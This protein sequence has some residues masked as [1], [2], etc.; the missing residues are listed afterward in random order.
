MSDALGLSATF[1]LRCRSTSS[2]APATGD[3]RIA[4]ASSSRAAAMRRTSWRRTRPRGRRHSSAGSRFQRR[5]RWRPTSCCATA[6]SMRK[7]RRSRRS[8]PGRFASRSHA[9]LAP[10]DAVVAE[11]GGSLRLFGGLS[12]LLARLTEGAR[13][14]GYAARL[15]ARAHAHAALVARTRPDMRR[16]CRDARALAAR[17]GAGLPLALLDVDADTRAT[18]ASAGITTFGEADALPRDG[19]ARRFG[20][21]LL[22]S[23]SIA[24]SARRARSARAVRAAAALRK[25][26]R[27][28][29]AGRRT[30]KRWR[31]RSTGSCTSS[32][33]GCTARGLGAL[34]LCAHARCTSAICTRARDRADD[35]A[36]RARRARARA[37]A[38]GRRVA[39]T[40]RARDAARAGRGLALASD[41]TAP[42][43]GRNL[44]LLPGD[45]AD[46]V[47]GSAARP[48]A[49][50]ARRRRGHRACAAR[51]A[52]SRARASRESANVAGPFGCGDARA[53]AS[54]PDAP[55]PL[56][57]LPEARAARHVLER[58][59]VGAAS[60]GPERIESGWWDGRRCA[61]R[62]LRRRDAAAAS[63][64]GS[65]AIIATAS[66]TANGS[67]TGGSR[68]RRRGASIPCDARADAI[69]RRST[70]RSARLGS[71]S[72]LVRRS[73]NEDLQPRTS[74]IG[75]AV[76]AG[77]LENPRVLCQQQH[78]F[79]GRCRHEKPIEWVCKR[80]VETPRRFDVARSDTQNSKPLRLHRFCERT[81]RQRQL[82][83]RALDQHFPQARRAHRTVGAG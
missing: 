7:P 46:D 64:P 10:P 77:K 35:R 83:A 75:S 48:L 69:R 70:P 44:G 49:R 24:R 22:R 40:A 52:P 43:A 71:P 61:S 62:L 42:L 79:L 11:I 30:S 80:A 57:L 74:T 34:R 28:A 55:R 17:A 5:S 19:L 23:V 14:Q 18:L 2:P 81:T 54:L 39:R 6:M 1:P 56:W 21:G 58:G 76:R 73:E 59:A 67:C 20:A 72:P 33:P 4:R 63:S 51:R 66:T 12:R 15:G 38:S 60:D 25:Q 8:R 32:R 31:S 82:A 36:V 9:S 78:P 26:A 53:A 50:A 68:E 27:A 65:I 37:G 47:R 45:E 41:E 13:A 3:G 29:R 16:L